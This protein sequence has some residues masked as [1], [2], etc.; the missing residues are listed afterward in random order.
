[1]ALFRAAIGLARGLNAE[2]VVEGIQS[3]KQIAMA[4]EVGAEYAHGFFCAEPMPFTLL[5]KWLEGRDYPTE[6]DDS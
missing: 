4:G 2:V 3:P 6:S 5:L 1:M